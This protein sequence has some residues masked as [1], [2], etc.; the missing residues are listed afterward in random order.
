MIK[1]NDNEK[2]TKAV[3]E[4]LLRNKEKHGAYYCP[5][6]LDKTPENICPCDEMQEKQ[7]CH[8]NLFVFEEDK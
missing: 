6:K 1:L 5:C 4:G 3:F 8:C 7:K 2:L